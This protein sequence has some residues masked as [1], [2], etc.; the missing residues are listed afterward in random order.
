MTFSR[1]ILVG[2]CAGVAVGVFLGELVAPLGVVGQGFVRLLQMTVLPYVFVSIILSLGSLDITEAKRLGLRAGAALASLWA[3]ALIFAFLFPLVFPPAETASFFSAALVE[4]P[5][6][7]DFVDLYIPSNPFHSLANNI[8]PAVVLFSV[9]TGIALIG[10]ERKAVLLDVLGVASDTI[11]RA[12]RFVVRLTPFGI[13]ALAATA[14][15][16]LRIEE[17]QRI[18]VYLVT[19][20]AISLLVAI[21]VLPGLVAA[22][23]PIPYREVLGPTRAALITAFSAG[24]LFIVLPIL[25]DACKDLLARHHVTDE[26]SAGLPDVIV[27]ASFNFPHTGKLLSLSFILF[28]GW[29]ADA[30]VPAHEYPRLALTGLLTF[31]GSLNAAVPFLLDSFRIPADTF[32]LFIATGVINSRFGALLAAVH[33]IVVA[34]LGSAAIAGTIRFEPRRLLRYV[35]V[36]VLITT[37]LVGGLRLTFRTVLRHEFKGAEL[38]YGMTNAFEHAPARVI[39]PPGEENDGPTLSRIRA[40]GALRVGFVQPRLP[41][42]FRNARQELVGLD[43]ELAHLL[44]RDLD[45]AVEFIEWP[46][47]ELADAV[48]RGRADIGIGGNAVTPT[49]ATSV[50]FSEPYLDETAAFVVKDY[51]RGRFETWT[52]IDAATDLVIGVPALPYYERLLKARLPDIPLKTFS[53]AQDPL[54]ERLGFDAVAL[55][56]ERGSVLTLLNPKWTVVVPSPGVI[57]VPLAFPLARQDEAWAAFVNTWIE[58]KRRDGTLGTLY[59]HWILGKAAE[60]RSPR[61]SVVRNVL[62]WVK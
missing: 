24:D 30:A 36:T 32:Q 21:W 38:V 8:V 56:A 62:H 39:P 40:R 20:V 29:F 22:L 44:A 6:A 51:L 59:D 41:F 17:I 4:K 54:D 5:D 58:M 50:L 23:T 18:E 52:S 42:V 25:I 11:S 16:T 26:R 9:T 35:V 43:V 61:W 53:V 33:T 48:S 3:V 47:G 31:F 1:R 10:V 34:L 60:N 37:A 55:P 15:G 57:K 28:A 19:Y 7:F 2:L 12:T 45:V 13:F 14:A 46:V 27:P 49:L